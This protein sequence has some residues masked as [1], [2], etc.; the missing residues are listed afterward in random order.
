MLLLVVAAA[1][2]ALA[3]VVMC[4]IRA[5]APVCRTCR[6]GEQAWIVTPG[7]ILEAA[8]LMTI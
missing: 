2:Y 4:I 5:A 6:S 3:D 8:A 1:A 7:T